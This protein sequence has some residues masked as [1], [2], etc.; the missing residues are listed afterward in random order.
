M[1]E[2]VN[3]RQ[4]TPIFVDNKCK[5]QQVIY[6]IVVLRVCLQQISIQL[7]FF[8]RALKISF[9]SFIDA[10]ELEK[11]RKPESHVIEEDVISLKIL[12]AVPFAKDPSVK[13]TSD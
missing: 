7:E 8:P 3:K 11:K 2:R 4:E 6:H 5:I 9:F 13:G 10:N 1:T 12:L